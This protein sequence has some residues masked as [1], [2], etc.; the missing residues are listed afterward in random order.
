MNVNSIPSFKGLMVGNS[1]GTKPYAINTDKIERLSSHERQ[2]YRDGK[3]Q[4]VYI[5]QIHLDDNSCLEV[6]YHINDV[7]KAYKAAAGSKDA[8]VDLDNPDKKL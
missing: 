6:P 8:L 1:T 7:L 2:G 4:H 3:Q 5:T